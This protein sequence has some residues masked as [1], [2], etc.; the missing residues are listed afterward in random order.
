MLVASAT[1]MSAM[2]TVH[3]DVHQRASQE[4]KEW[5]RREKVD[6]VFGEQKIQRNAAQ[7]DEADRR[8]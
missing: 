3:E 5:E 7:H 2:P 1:S 4:Q 8:T 6:A